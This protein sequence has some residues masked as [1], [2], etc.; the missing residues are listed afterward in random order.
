[1]KLL[2]V[3]CLV[4]ASV[5]SSA[6]QEVYKPGNGVTLPVVIKSV[7]PDYTPEAQAQRIQG[8]ATLELVVNTDGGVSDVK[9][10]KSLDSMFGLDKQAVKAAEEWKFRP[11]AKDGKPVRVSVMLEMN[12]TLK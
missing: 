6:A 8:T 10:V 5:V 9:V 4:A 1:M 2:A 3:A 11:G 7:K 12:F